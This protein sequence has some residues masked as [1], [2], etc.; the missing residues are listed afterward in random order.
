MIIFK[1]YIFK[2]RPICSVLLASHVFR[3]IALKE[4]LGPTAFRVK[5]SIKKIQ[6]V[7][8]GFYYVDSPIFLLVKIII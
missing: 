8:T 4:E 2:Y 7:A 5:N 1:Y 6:L 3:N